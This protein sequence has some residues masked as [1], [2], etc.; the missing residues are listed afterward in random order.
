[1]YWDARYP[2][3]ISLDFLEKLYRNGNPKLT[4]IGDITC[5]ANGSI[6]C[7]H[8]GTEIEN[9]VFIY[10]PAT[11]VNTFGFEGDGILDMAVDILPS[12]LPRDSSD[13]FADVLVNFI[14]PIVFADYDL[15]F[16]D[17]DL[18]K[19]LKKALILHKGKLTHEYEYLRE[20]LEK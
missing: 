8:H 4:V 11:K 16:E 13:G 7:T 19:S 14:K 18:P 3:L 5:D 6:E 15:P 9:P 17:L 2:R 10:N 1:M 12:E 20:Y